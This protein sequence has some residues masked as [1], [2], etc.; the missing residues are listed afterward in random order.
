MQSRKQSLSPFLPATL[1]P[2]ENRMQAGFH[3]LSQSHQWPPDCMAI[4]LLG[5]AP[6][7]NSQV[8]VRGWWMLSHFSQAV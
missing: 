6:T 4:S 2:E 1:P 7:G 5:W 8:G 3:F